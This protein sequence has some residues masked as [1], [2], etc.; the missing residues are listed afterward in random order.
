MNKATLVALILLAGVAYLALTGWYVDRRG[1]S[2]NV[3]ETAHSTWMNTATSGPITV[4]TGAS[5]RVS[6]TTTSAQIRI[7]QNNSPFSVYLK[8]GADAAATANNGYLLSAS[9]TLTLTNEN[10]S[11]YQ[12][13]VQGISTG[14]TATV[15]VN[16]N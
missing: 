15:L 13:S 11:M 4:G 6:A 1:E 3:G 12:G 9:S 14:G 2:S 5:V 8:F 16:E 10:G 7:F